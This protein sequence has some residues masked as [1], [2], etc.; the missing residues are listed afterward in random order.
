MFIY[1]NW[2]Y[3]VH[4]TPGLDRVQTGSPRFPIHFNTAEGG[5]ENSHPTI[6]RS[7]QYIRQK[8]R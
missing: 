6:S 5:L 2:K 1:R 4:N 7:T 3:I 8:A